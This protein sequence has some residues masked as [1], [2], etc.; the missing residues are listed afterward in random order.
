MHFCSCYSVGAVFLQ[1]EVVVV[2]GWGGAEDRES[3]VQ[4]VGE[5][6][7]VPTCLVCSCMCPRTKRAKHQ[8]PGPVAWPPAPA[9]GK[10][11]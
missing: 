2:G 8:Q 11:Q 9:G 3:F 7:S 4:W 10:Q 6:R 1:G 5:E